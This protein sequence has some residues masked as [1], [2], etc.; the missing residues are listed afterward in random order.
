MAVRVNDTKISEAVKLI[1]EKGFDGMAEAVQILFN[2]A[3]LIERNRYMQ[4]EPYERSE[5]RQDYANGFKPKQL[6]TK[7]GELSLQIPQVRSSDF[8]PSFLEKGVRSERALK[9][10]LAEM[11]VQGVS[12]RKVEKVLQEL[13]GLQVTSTEVSRAS[14]LLDEELRSWKTR[15]LGSYR[16]LFV[17]ARYEKVRREGCVV[18]SAVLIAYG[19][20]EHGKREV[21]GISV[22]LSEAEVH[23]RTFL[24]SLVKRGLH[25]LE[26]IISDAHV[27]LKAALK[28]VFPSIPWQRCQFHLQQNAQAY[29]TKH[30]RKRE[31]AETLRAIFNAQNKSEAERLLKLAIDYYQKD[32][33][34]LSQWMEENITEGLTVFHFPSEHRRR[35]RTSNMAERV[36]AEIRRR[37]RVARIFPNV[38]SCERLVGAIVM[39]ISEDWIAGKVYLNLI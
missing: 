9:I 20:N 6:K 19:I 39:E 17:D 29:V 8:Y 35:L 25:G 22:S 33:P 3:M 23:W 15:L 11:Y 7:L 18:D 27:G 26:L 32:M 1:V 38:E 21:L 5:L 28:A 34:P 36:N 31:V 24:E 10:A 30:S 37:S 16:F 2:E 4:V 12:T 13:C 14:K